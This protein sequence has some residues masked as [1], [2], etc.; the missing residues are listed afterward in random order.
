MIMADFV[1]K[2]FMKHPCNMYVFGW[3]IKL[4]FYYHFVV[5][6]VVGGGGGGGVFIL[7]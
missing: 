7:I 1:V 3:C 5:V 2:T 4:Y 6:V